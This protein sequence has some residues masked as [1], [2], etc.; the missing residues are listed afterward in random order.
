MSAMLRQGQFDSCICQQHAPATK[1]W[2]H[3]LWIAA[4]VAR[5]IRNW[6]ARLRQRHDLAVLDDWL[7][8]D[9]GVTRQAALREA[10]KPFWILH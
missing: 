4:E 6:I 1:A 8:R 10:R 3:P 2:H 9:I 5:T 7:L